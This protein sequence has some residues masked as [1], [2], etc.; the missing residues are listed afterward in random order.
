MTLNTKTLAAAALAASI[1]VPAAASAHGFDFGEKGGLHLGAFIGGKGLHVGDHM[2]ASST[3]GLTHKDGDR[4]NE[5]R[6]NEHENVFKGERSQSASTTAAV[7]TAKG[8]RLSAIA[9]FMGSLSGNLST[10]IANA[11]L[12]ASSSATANAKLADY[13]TTTAAA[14]VQANTAVTAASGIND[15]NS[16]TTNATLKTNAQADIKAAREFLLQAQRDLM[17]ILHI[18]FGH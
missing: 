18:V 5:D 17:A 9:D 6:D 12:S 10:R 11:N 15:Q 1:L 7:L 3:V 16:T 13:S 4:D 14:K 8:N 2:S